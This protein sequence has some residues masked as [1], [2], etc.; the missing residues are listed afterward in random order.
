[1]IVDFYLSDTSFARVVN[2][3]ILVFCF[4]A[5]SFD[6]PRVVPSRGLR[7][8]FCHAR[9]AAAGRPATG[10]EWAPHSYRLVTLATVNQYFSKRPQRPLTNGIVQWACTSKAH[11]VLSGEEKVR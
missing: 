10:L 1:M 5:T 4:T 2:C 6:Q 3:S 7:A 8:V 11:S 9:D